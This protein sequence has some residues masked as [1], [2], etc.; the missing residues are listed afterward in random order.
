VRQ[1]LKTTKS[2][3]EISSEI[4]KASLETIAHLETTPTRLGGPSGRRASLDD[5]PPRDSLGSIDEGDE[6]EDDD[7]YGE[8]DGDL[9]SEDEE[10]D[11]D[12]ETHRLRDLVATFQE[13]CLWRSIETSESEKRNLLLEA[14][15]QRL[16]R[17]KQL[18]TDQ[19]MARDQE[20][21]TLH[22]ENQKLKAQKAVLVKEVKRLQPYTQ[23]NLSALIREAEEARMMQRSLQAQLQELLAGKSPETDHPVS[24]AAAT[25]SE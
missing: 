17:D 13:Q 2:E 5:A 23:V 9:E 21:T 10:A 19:L 6:E 14:E 15:L 22:T 4:Y 18:L 20:A 12:G 8:H 7:S 25:N 24:Q 1:E 16:D 11:A 3:L